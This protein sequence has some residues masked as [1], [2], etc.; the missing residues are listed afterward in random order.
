MLR[1]RIHHLIDDLFD[2]RERREHLADLVGHL[3]QAVD[4]SLQTRLLAPA[5]PLCELF[6]QLV[7]A[8]IIGRVGRCGHGQRPSPPP[9]R[10]PSTSSNAVAP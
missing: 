5:I 10:V 3:R 1:E 6:S 2:L 9:G 4:V 7:E 8:A